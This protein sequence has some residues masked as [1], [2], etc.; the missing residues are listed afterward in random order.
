[1]GYLVDITKTRTGVKIKQYMRGK[2]HAW[3]FKV[4]AR[5]GVSGMLY[6]FDV[7]QGNAGKT[8]S[9]FGLATDVVLKLTST[10]SAG[11]NYKIFADSFFTSTTLISDHTVVAA[12]N[13]LYRDG[14]KWSSAQLPAQG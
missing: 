10:L 13:S 5:T 7:Y 12:W 1:M 11:C 2:P 3:G 14:E 9:E 4:W 8:N 6:D